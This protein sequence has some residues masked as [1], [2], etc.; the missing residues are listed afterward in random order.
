MTSVDP[1]IADRMP[2]FCARRDGKLEKK[3]AFRR[4][5]PS[6]AMS[7]K[8]A[9]SV[10]TPTMRHATPMHANTR[11]QRFWRAMRRR[12]P[13]SFCS[14]GSVPGAI[15]AISVGLAE[16]A[17][18][19]VAEHVEA[20]RDEEE[21]EAGREDRLVTD[22]AV[23]KVAEGHLHYVGGDRGRGLGGVEGELRLHAC[24]DRDHHGLA[25]GARDAE[26]VGRGD[27]RHGGGHHRSEERR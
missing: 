22:G 14:C 23:R 7:T 13:R 20:E 11:S 26:D 1:T 6:I 10:S 16:S 2:A 24:R 19:E 5:T 3:S 18:E 17:L 15:A 21:R 4:G 25:H 9:T 27:A 12:S 8:S